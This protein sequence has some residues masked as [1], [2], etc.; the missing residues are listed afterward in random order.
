LD[1]AEKI[2]RGFKAKSL[3]NN[4]FFNECFDHLEQLYVEAWKNAKTADAREDAH[5]FVRLIEWL[6][7]DLTNIA[8]SGKLEEARVKQLEAERQMPKLSEFRR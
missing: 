6:K 7:V 8:E 1:S 4:D 5:K 2:E 3:L